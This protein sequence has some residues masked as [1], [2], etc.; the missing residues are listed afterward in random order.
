MTLRFFAAVD[1]AVLVRAL[2]GLPTMRV[3]PVTAAADPRLTA[4]SAQ[5]WVLPVSGLDR[6]A[7]A[8]AELTAGL[9]PAEDRPFRGHH[10][11]ARTRRRG[12]LR[13]L[14]VPDLS[15]EPPVEWAVEE[16]AAFSSVLRPDGAEHRLLGRWSLAPR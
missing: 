6:L 5:V 13:G 15:G 14:P 3:G 7:T 4:L 2:S 10:T 16:V 11:Q 1:P 9:G 8:V 12:G